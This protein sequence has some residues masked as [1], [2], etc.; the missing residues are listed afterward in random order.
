M[1]QRMTNHGTFPRIPY[2]PATTYVNP[3]IRANVR[4]PSDGSRLFTVKEHMTI[5]QVIRQLYPNGYVVDTAK[6]E[7]DFVESVAATVPF[8]LNISPDELYVYFETLGYAVPTKEDRGSP[9]PSTP[10]EPQKD[11]FIKRV[12]MEDFQTRDYDVIE[13]SRRTLESDSEASLDPRNPCMPRLG[14][15]TLRVNNLRRPPSIDIPKRVAAAIRMLKSK[16]HADY[17]H[18]LFRVY[19]MM[20]SRKL[21][22]RIETAEVQGLYVRA[23]NQPRIH[24]IEP[25]ESGPSFESLIPIIASQLDPSLPRPVSLLPEELLFQTILQAVVHVE[26]YRIAL[27]VR[28]CYR[29]TN[30]AYKS[31]SK[32]CRFCEAQFVTGEIKNHSLTQ[33]KDILSMFEDFLIHKDKLLENPSARLD[34]ML[35]LI[36]RIFIGDSVRQ[37]V[38][39]YENG[40][41]NKQ[42]MKYFTFWSVP[43]VMSRDSYA[44]LFTDPEV[45][46]G[47]ESSSSASSSGS[48]TSDSSETSTSSS[49]SDD[50][51]S[52][53]SSSSTS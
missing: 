12:H 36:P 5:C 53:S 52:S 2:I 45:I 7:Q 8:Y 6:D 32:A 48:S 31:V 1:K 19:E 11:F 33:H 21:P 27:F 14:V 37:V 41:F 15:A 30:Q 43:T 34:E 35:E 49:D 42:P 44:R 10:A 18:T 3:T 17:I 47:A 29:N 39:E 46:R 13:L 51:S 38:M 20:R 9:A 26:E 40:L 25:L 4:R 23:H 28:L 50:S 22:P 16:D 24:T